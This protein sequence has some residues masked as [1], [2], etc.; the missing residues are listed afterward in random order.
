MELRE[1]RDANPEHLASP[2]FARLISTVP[3]LRLKLKEFDKNN[4]GN[5]PEVDEIGQDCLG[6]WRLSINSLLVFPKY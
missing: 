4:P 5:H 1:W 2:E 6:R 3:K